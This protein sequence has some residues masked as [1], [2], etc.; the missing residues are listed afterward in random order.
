MKR[1]LVA[2]GLLL[3]SALCFATDDYNRTP[4]N[5]GAQAPS[6]GYFYVAEGWSQPCANGIMY[7]DLTT[8]AG[9]SMWAA[10][11]AAKSLGKTIHWVNYTVGSGNI[12][13][14]SLIEIS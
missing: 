10:V 2:T 7:I 13:T 9:K 8:A 3:A 1:F 12:C 14:A 5:M 11:L 4:V 6:S